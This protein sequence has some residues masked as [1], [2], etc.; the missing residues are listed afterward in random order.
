MCVFPRA[1]P[2]RGPRFL[3]GG[4]S[5]T[6]VNP[7]IWF[8]RAIQRQ[9]PDIMLQVFKARLT[10]KNHTEFAATPLLRAR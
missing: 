4:A 5:N 8:V 7:K 6:T 3:C 2:A 1:G 10:R 9:L